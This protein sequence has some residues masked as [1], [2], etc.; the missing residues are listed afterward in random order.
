MATVPLELALL[1]A[2]VLFALGLAGVLLRRNIIF[3]LLSIEIM[4]NAAGLAF[5]VAGARWQQVDGQVMFLFILSMAAA[6]VAVGLALVLQMVHRFGTVDS[7]VVSRMR[8]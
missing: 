4:L 6:E 3:V 1:L 2:G 5:I 8:G 7:D